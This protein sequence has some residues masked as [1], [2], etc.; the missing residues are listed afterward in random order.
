MPEKVITFQLIRIRSKVKGLNKS[1]QWLSTYE[2]YLEEK[3]EKALALVWE[4]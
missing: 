3:K 2:G 4:S 1:R